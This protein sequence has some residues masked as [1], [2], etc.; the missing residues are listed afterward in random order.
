MSTKYLL[1]NKIRPIG[2]ALLIITLSI[3][4]SRI[5]FKVDYSWL[6][7]DVFAI[8][9]GGFLGF[10]FFTT[11][12]QNLIYPI[13][14]IFAILG[15]TLLAVTKEREEKPQYNELRAES[16]LLTFHIILGIT[17]FSFMFFYDF[18]LLYVIIFTLF[19]PQIS[20]F[21]IFQIKRRK[22]DKNNNA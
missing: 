12:R 16:I 14:F 11:T 5:V 13:T 15:V 8:I 3:I 7:T 17:I 10:E 4:F 1:P 2:L 6:K 22:I 21:L 19:L 20:Y 9:T 18:A